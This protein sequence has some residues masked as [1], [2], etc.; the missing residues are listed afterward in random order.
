MSEQ[1]WS[2]HATCWPGGCVGVNVGVA[3]GVGVVVG[4]GVGV[5]VGVGVGEGEGDG[6]GV[7]IWIVKGAENSELL[8]PASVRIAVMFGPANEPVNVQLPSRS[9]CVVPS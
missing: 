7:A 4:V 9:V 6:V 1:L 8:P 3:V 5:A 2:P